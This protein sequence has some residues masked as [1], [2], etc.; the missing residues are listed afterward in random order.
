MK[1]EPNDQF[2][3]PKI[4]YVCNPHKNTECTKEMCYLNKNNGH[5]R[6]LCF[7]TP[8][9]EYAVLDLDG[10]PVVDLS[11]FAYMVSNDFMKWGDA[12]KLIGEKMA[13]LLINRTVKR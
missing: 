6:G 4:L 9:T 3:M 2:K 8:K 1:Q 13:L 5:Q 11:H 10:D 7:G 12:K